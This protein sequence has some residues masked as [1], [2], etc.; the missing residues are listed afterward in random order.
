MECLEAFDHGSMIQKSKAAIQSMNDIGYVL[1]DKEY[2]ANQKKVAAGAAQVAGPIPILYGL[3]VG[4]KLSL[5]K[6]TV[7]S[8]M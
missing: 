2:S 7:L 3:G 4:K 6:F 1:R 5:D 8:L